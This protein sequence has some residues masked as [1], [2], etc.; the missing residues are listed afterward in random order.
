MSQVIR[1]TRGVG[2]FGAVLLKNGVMLLDG[3]TAPVDG[4]SGT[5][6]GYAGPGSLYIRTTTGVVYSNTGTKASPVWTGGV[7]TTAAAVDSLQGFGVARATF[8]PTANSGE[9]TTGAHTFGVTI[10]DKAI[11]CGGVV[12]VNAAFTSAASTAT[13]AISIQSANDIITAAAVS[14]APFSTTGLKAITPQLN[15]LESTSIALTAARL[16]TAT[17]GVQALLLGKAT[18]NL[19]YLMGA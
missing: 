3:T 11:V 15:T 9:R 8:N 10:P 16:I 14:G 18:I 5:G 1:I 6:V 4:T 17:V 13:V 19:I 12:Q 2:S 7:S